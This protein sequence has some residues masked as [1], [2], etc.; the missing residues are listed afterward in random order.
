[1]QPA[2]PL[3]R[4]LLQTASSIRVRLGCAIPGHTTTAGATASEC[5]PREQG[6]TLLAA[7][8]RSGPVQVSPTS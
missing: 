7:G 4:R 3:S 5:E 6:E 8:P 2:P 1:M